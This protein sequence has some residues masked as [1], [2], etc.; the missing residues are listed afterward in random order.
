MIAKIFGVNIDVIKDKESRR[1]LRN[2]AKREGD[3]ISSMKYGYIYVKHDQEV[4]EWQYL[5]ID[6]MDEKEIKKVKAKCLFFE[7]PSALMEVIDNFDL[8]DVALGDL[9]FIN[10]Q[11]KE[12]ARAKKKSFM[13]RL[14]RILKLVD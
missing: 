9:D 5:E 14:G 13:M 10:E 12:K 8:L 11:E 7:S 6:G 1:L 4:G 3:Y 2:A